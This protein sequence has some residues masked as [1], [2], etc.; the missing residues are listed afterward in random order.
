MSIVKTYRFRLLAYSAILM[1]FL[2]GILVEAVALLFVVWLV[3][4]VLAANAERITQRV[5]QHRTGKARRG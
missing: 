5:K 1:L 3:I 4:F 2:V